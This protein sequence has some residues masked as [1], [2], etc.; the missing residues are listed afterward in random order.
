MKGSNNRLII[1]R[2]SIDRGGT[3]QE[4]SRSPAILRTQE[5]I[6]TTMEAITMEDICTMDQ[7]HITTVALR[8]AMGMEEAAARTVPTL[9]H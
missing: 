2:G 9:Q 3:L 6:T 7:V 4:L 5:D 8:M 1:A